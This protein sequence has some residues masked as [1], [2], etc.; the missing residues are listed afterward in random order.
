M[1]ENQVSHNS[2]RL[3]ILKCLLYV[4]ISFLCICSFSESIVA[5][6]NPSINKVYN[7]W[8]TGTQALTTIFS[9]LVM[10][11]LTFSPEERNHLN[12][13]K[14]FSFFVSA[15]G[16][17]EL[18]YLTDAGPLKHF[19]FSDLSISS[20]L[21]FMVSTIVLMGETVN[22]ELSFTKNE[23]IPSNQERK[24]DVNLLVS[25]LGQVVGTCGFLM[26]SI[27]GSA[28]PGWNHIMLV[29]FIIGVASSVILFKGDVE[30]LHNSLF[31][32]EKLDSA[33]QDTATALVVI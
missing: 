3:K 31:S 23:K 24:V 19:T 11:I 26:Q 8:L 15:I 16:C 28:H 17:I 7:D 20:S 9:L 13:L 30:N 18:I 4:L 25:C 21:C 29:C 1:G 5:C 2:R 22:A 10:A 12:R 27:A 6:F 32:N 33:E 14:I